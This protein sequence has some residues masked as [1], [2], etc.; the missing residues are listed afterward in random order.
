VQ[1]LASLTGWNVDEIRKKAHL[2]AG[3][4]DASAKWWERI[5]K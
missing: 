3:G 1:T 5:W 4:A 2:V